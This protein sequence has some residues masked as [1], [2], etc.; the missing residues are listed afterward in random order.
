MS[1][2]R[3]LPRSVNQSPPCL[4]NTRSFGPFSGCSPHLV[5]RVSILP[6]ER[7]TRW[8]EPP[9]YSWGAGAP[10]IMV[11]REATQPKPPLLQTYIMPSGP[12]AAPLGPPG[13]CATTSLRP[14]GHTRV[15]RWP[16]IS[17]ST[18]EPSGITTGPS[19]NSR[20]VASTRT[21]GI[22][23][24]RLFLGRGGFQA[25]S[26]RATISLRRV[27]AKTISLAKQSRGFRRRRAAPRGGLFPDRHPDLEPAITGER[28]EILVVALEAGRIRGLQARGRQPV[29]PDRVDG[30]ADGRDVVGMGEDR[31]ALCGNPHLRKFARQVGKIRHFD[32]G[33]V[34]EIAGVVA[35][36]ADAVSHLPDPSGNVVHRLMKAVPLAWNAGAVLVIVALAETGD[37]QRRA[38]FKTR[39]LKIVGAG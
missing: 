16:R 22:K 25:Q 15:S 5:N 38:G 13:I 9:I 4:S 30:A 19:G 2:A 20:P 14:S 35:V 7:S 17:T 29:I 36:A 31:I 10:G 24:S 37:E 27:M 18:T 21:L 6:V 8:I 1:R 26:A 39:R 33:D 3:R 23:S 32:T 12:S 11:P 34:V 28:I